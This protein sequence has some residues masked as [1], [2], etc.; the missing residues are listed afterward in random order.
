VLAEKFSFKTVDGTT[1]A[2]KAAFGWK[3]GTVA[4]A[5]P[6]PSALRAVEWKRHAIVHRGGTIDDEYAR[7]AGLDA[8]LLGTPLELDTNAVVDDINTVVVQGGHL[9]ARLALWLEAVEP[10]SASFKKRGNLS[11][12]DRVP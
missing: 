5:F 4:P 7:K 8:S 10:V 6:D 9:L 1:A 3:A 2:Y 12:P 11:R